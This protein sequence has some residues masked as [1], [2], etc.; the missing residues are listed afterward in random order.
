MNSKNEGHK[1]VREGKKSQ[2]R[3]VINVSMSNVL[4]GSLPANVVEKIVKDI[5][6]IYY[7]EE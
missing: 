1:L 4:K 2:V 6:I 5:D 7:G 3:D